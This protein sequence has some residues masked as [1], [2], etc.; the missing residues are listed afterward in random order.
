MHAY[1]S[2]PAKV[3]I[4]ACFLVQ[5]LKHHESYEHIIMPVPIYQVICQDIV[6]CLNKNIK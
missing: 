1:L 2:F 3:N 6:I 4:F 5:K